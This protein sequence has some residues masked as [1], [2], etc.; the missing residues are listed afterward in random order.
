MF[1]IFQDVQDVTEE[2]MRK[3]QMCRGGVLLASWGSFLSLQ[4]EIRK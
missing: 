3:V 1:Q 2:D 4:Y